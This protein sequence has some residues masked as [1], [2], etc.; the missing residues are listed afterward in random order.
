MNARADG[1]GVHYDAME[2]AE[3]LRRHGNGI[4]ADTVVVLV[5][6]KPTLSTADAVPQPVVI[7]RLTPFAAVGYYPCIAVRH[8]Y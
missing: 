4:A 1:D 8:H 2:V 5:S 3:V 6:T 7:A